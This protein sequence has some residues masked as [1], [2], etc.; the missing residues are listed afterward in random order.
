MSTIESYVTP[1]LRE[2]R[3]LLEQVPE[4]EVDGALQALL[5]A[6]RIFLLGAGRTGLVMEMLAMRLVQ[7]GKV[8]FVVGD[9]TTPAIRRGDLLVV[10]SGSGETSSVVLLTK[11][12]VQAGA[13]VVAFVGERESALGRLGQVI[14]SF[15]G[16]T[17][18]TEGEM[19]SHLPLA[20][21]FELALLILVDCIVG[22]AA[23]TSGIR[24]ERMSARHANLE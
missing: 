12:A 24:H 14:V 6:E 15:P 13:R 16:A 19:A 3:T 21:A 1:V 11:R 4:R 22:M 8:A 18:K 17:S 9:S 5:G 7:L 23:E 10:G 2:L 20:S